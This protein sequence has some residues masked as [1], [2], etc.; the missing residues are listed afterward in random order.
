MSINFN[1]KWKQI[2]NI[3]LFTLVI[4][5]TCTLSC[6]L[7]RS[8]THLLVPHTPTPQCRFDEI[9]GGDG[10]TKRAGA[11]GGTGG[12]DAK[13][14]RGGGGTGFKSG[15]GS[16]GASAGAGGRKRRRREAVYDWRTVLSDE[17]HE[18][19]ECM[20]NDFNG[21]W[22]QG[23][24]WWTGR[25]IPPKNAPKNALLTTHILYTSQTTSFLAPPGAAPDIR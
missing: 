4:T 3:Q 22:G 1:F 10:G 20:Q 11:S 24:F 9:E 7:S 19:Q 13:K 16:A 17:S 21:E 23:Q 12:S 6:S 18:V 2:D 8:L 5:L 25:Q 14:R 15:L